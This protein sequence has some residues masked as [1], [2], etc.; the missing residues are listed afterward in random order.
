MEK[1]RPTNPKKIATL[2]AVSQSQ[3]AFFEGMSKR[4]DDPLAEPPASALAALN[5]SG[6]GRWQQ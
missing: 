5:G 3:G 1:N 4:S 2:A 6:E